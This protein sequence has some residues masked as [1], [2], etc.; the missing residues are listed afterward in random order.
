MRHLISSLLLGSVAFFCSLNAQDNS[1]LIIFLQH[2]RS[3][4]EDFKREALPDIETFAE[5]QKIEV[6][7]LDA[8]DGA[9]AEVKFTP[10]IFYQNDRGRSLYHGRYHDVKHL[11]SFVGKARKSSE[12]GKSSVPENSAVWSVGRATLAAP[13]KV[14]PLAGNV[15]GGFDQDQFA[16]EAYQS[17]AAGMDYFKMNNQGKFSGEVRKFHMEFSPEKT[18][19]GLLLVSMKLFSEFNPGEPVFETQIPSGGE[20]D[21][22]DFVWRKAGNRLE[23]ALIAQIS[24]WDNGDGFDTLSEKTPVKSWQEIK[25]GT[26]TSA[27]FSK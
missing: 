27:S 3:M 26:S 14:N 10:A 24:N 18:K 19:D 7:I 12:Q 9:P 23:K 8:R 17:I 5:R 15:P 25:I 11:E 2:G 4:T 1:Q 20:W 6:K 21:N 13:L 22:P 16:R